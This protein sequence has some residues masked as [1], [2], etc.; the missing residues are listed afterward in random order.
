MVYKLNK[1][2]LK[3]PFLNIFNFFYKKFKLFKK[4]KNKL[5]PKRHEKISKVVSRGRVYVHQ[6][7]VWIKL[8]LTRYHVNY[9]FG[10]FACTKKP[11]LFRPKKKK[12]KRNSRR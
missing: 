6:G 2:K 11:F 3:I 5:R 4:Y 12:N 10:E 7:R 1:K 8:L 9:K